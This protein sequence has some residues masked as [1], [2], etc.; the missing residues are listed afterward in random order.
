M[1]EMQQA[2]TESIWSPKQLRRKLDVLIENGSTQLVVSALS[3]VSGDKIS[4]WK[5]GW[6]T[7]TRER[8]LAVQRT[9][10]GLSL[11]LEIDGSKGMNDIRKL[12]RR[13]REIGMH[14]AAQQIPQQWGVEF[15]ERFCA[16]AKLTLEEFFAIA[17]LHPRV[18]RSARI[19]IPGQRWIHGWSVAIEATLRSKNINATFENFAA[20]YG[21]RSAALEALA[22]EAFDGMLESCGRE[23]I[24]SHT[25]QLVLSGELKAAP[26][27]RKT[28]NARSKLGGAGRACGSIHPDAQRE[29]RCM[30]DFRDAPRCR[31]LCPVRGDVRIWRRI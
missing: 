1:T 3:E 17:Q 16:L 24:L 29:I 15:A 28:K 21:D 6:K 20:D 31:H 7:P 8:A 13:L 9:V 4:L 5:N 18:A 10:E 27:D 25:A 2:F 22:R 23:E 12:R 30:E 11:L 14:R 19:S 26:R